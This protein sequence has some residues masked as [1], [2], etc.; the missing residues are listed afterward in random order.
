LGGWSYPPGLQHTTA[1]AV[2]AGVAAGATACYAVRARDHNGNLSAWS[3]AACWSRPLDD[4][5]LK[6][7]TGWSR[8]KGSV[9]YAHT[10]TTSSRKGAALTR[11]HVHA[12]ALL[13]VVTKC[14]TCGS[15]GIYEGT[16]LVTKLALTASATRNRVPI[17]IKLPTVANGATITLRVL[18]SGKPIRIDA[19]GPRP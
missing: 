16:R 3:A 15:V 12:T 11:T 6:A 13:L 19:L 17:T 8:G 1:T 9:Y 10:V 14:R 2:T 7:S 5:A 18:T 4:R